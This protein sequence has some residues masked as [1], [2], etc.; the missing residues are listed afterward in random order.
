MKESFVTINNRD[1]YYTDEGSGSVIVLLHGYLETSEIWSDFSRELSS[2]FRV[3][4]FDL[5]GHGKSNILQDHSIEQ[6]A[7]TINYALNTLSVTQCI[8]I[9]HSMGGYVTLMIHKLHPEKLFAF[10]LF[11]SHPF[12]DTAQIKKR[13]LR[14]IEFV[15]QG[16][17]E[18]IATMTIPNAFARI[19]LEVLE[20]E[21]N[22]TIKIALQNT[23]QGIVCNLHAMRKR[24]DLSESLKKSEIP[25]LLILGKHDDYI[26]CNTIVSKIKL[27]PKT[28]VFVLNNSGHM[29]FIEEKVKSLEIIRDFALKLSS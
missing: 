25:F 16:K 1:I 20:K 10:C 7:Q 3:I 27:P 6:I 28:S 4:C 23:E 18:L 14:E 15:N 21:I 5:P 17:K 22:K 29:G 8:M 26:D 9:G 2:N 12:A 19:N 11:H 24:D 13:R